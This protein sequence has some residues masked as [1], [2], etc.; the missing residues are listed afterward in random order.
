MPLNDAAAAAAA[1]LIAAALQALS[2]VDKKN[3]SKLWEEVL[4]ELNDYLKT[5]TVVTTTGVT[6]GSGSAPGTLS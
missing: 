5:N 1:P 6:P 4:K 2:D 3:A